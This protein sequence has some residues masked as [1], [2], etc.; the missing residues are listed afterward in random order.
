[1]L[2]NRYLMLIVGVLLS[3]LF[4]TGFVLAQDS[5]DTEVPDDLGDTTFA[6]VQLNGDTPAFDATITYV[7]GAFA[8]TTGC[9][10]YRMGVTFE[11]DTLTTT[12]GI[13]T[14]MACIEPEQAE[15]EVRFLEAMAAA[16]LIRSKMV[17]SQFM[18][19]MAQRFWFLRSPLTH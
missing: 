9:N 10:N 2:N 11:G 17:N 19:L 14:L 13:Q 5:A 18:T 15:Q 4:S 1:M 3:L 7:D 16:R 12:P 8:G 6:L